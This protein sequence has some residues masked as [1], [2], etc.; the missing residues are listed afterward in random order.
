MVET[1]RRLWHHGMYRQNPWLQKVVD[2]WFDIWVE[3]RTEATMQ[4]VD[5][6]V[7]KLNPNPVEVVEPVYWEEEKGETPLGGTI[8]YTYEFSAD[9]D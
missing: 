2:N 4:D 3:V 8:G 1:I 7:K 6:Q 5:R 9:E